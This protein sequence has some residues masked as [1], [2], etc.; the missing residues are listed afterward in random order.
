MQTVMRVI[1]GAISV[2]MLLLVLRVLL[3]WFQGSIGGR[4]VDLLKRVTDP[5]LDLFRRITFLRTE[6]VDFSPLAA[7]LVLGILISILNTIASY[8]TITFGI[9]L[10][11]IISAIWSSAS[12]IITFFLIL[13]A[14]R[15]VMLLVNEHAVSPYVATLDAILRPYLTWLSGVLLRGRP[16]AY[17]GILL[18]GIAS[19][20]LVNIVGKLLIRLLVGLLFRLP[21]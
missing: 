1:T 12:W 8:G 10:A 7:F 4:G 2:Y 18:Y 3:T 14:I 11:I 15:L 20:L 5:Y 17:R 21:F 16:I 13:E 19:L 6:R 9:I